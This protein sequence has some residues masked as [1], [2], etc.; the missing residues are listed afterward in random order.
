MV[1]SYRFCTIDGCGS[2]FA[3]TDFTYPTLTRLD[4]GYSSRR[5]LAGCSQMAP[6]EVA[7]ATP[8]NPALRLVAGTRRQAAVSEHS[9]SGYRSRSG[10]INHPAYGDTD[11][12]QL[13]VAGR[14]ALRRPIGYARE[15]EMAEHRGIRHSRLYPSLRMADDGAA[16]VSG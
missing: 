9:M 10:T 13:A 2:G 11:Y 8:G 1:G 3:C 12:C 4:T 14:H 5:P 6:E 15:R 16:L 7:D